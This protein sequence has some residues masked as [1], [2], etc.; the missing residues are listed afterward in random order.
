MMDF[1]AE[2]SNLEEIIGEEQN[3]TYTII[4][5]RRRKTEKMVMRII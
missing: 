1:I 2:V 3:Y 5:T 4:A